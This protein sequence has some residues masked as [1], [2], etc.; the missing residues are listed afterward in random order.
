MFRNEGGR[1]AISACW[2]IPC[3]QPV[4]YYWPSASGDV[5]IRLRQSLSA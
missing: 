4:D 2:K 5:I 3:R 1:D